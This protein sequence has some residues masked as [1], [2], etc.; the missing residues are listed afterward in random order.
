[1]KTFA[2]ANNITIVIKH[3]NNLNISSLKFL[4]S[5]FDTIIAIEN[6]VINQNIEISPNP[7]KVPI[8][9]CKQMISSGLTHTYFTGKSEKARRHF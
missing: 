6:I 3:D 1:M 5:T 8:T 2:H 7:S 4:L 9:Q